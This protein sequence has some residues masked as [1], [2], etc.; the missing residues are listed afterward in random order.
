MTQKFHE[1]FSPVILENDV[2]QDFI[3]IINKAGDEVL[4]SKTKSAKWDWSHKLVGK[5]YKEIQIPLADKD[6]IKYCQTFIKQSCLDYLNFI[7]EKFTNY[8]QC[9]VFIGWKCIISN[10]S[11]FK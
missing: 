10:C 2:P 9:T 8:F 1:P 3:D 4:N 6:E 11:S 7:R 5:V